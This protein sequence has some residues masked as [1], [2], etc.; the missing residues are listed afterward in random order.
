MQKMMGGIGAEPACFLYE[1]YIELLK[2]SPC[3]RKRA[4]GGLGSGERPES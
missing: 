2:N 4:A 3:P 1:E